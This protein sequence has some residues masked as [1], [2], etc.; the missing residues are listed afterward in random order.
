MT[1]LAAV[2]P[3]CRN[4]LPDA[5]CNIGAPVRCPT[6]DT[7]V[8]VEIFPAFHRS[9]AAGPAA[10][11]ILEE[12]VSSCF[13]HEQKKAVVHCD[14]CGRFLCALCDL[15]FDGQHFCPG[16]LQTGKTTG[17]MP[18]LERRRTLYDSAALTLVFVPVLFLPV[19]IV[20]APVAIYLAVLSWFRP[21]SV[22]Q[23][24]RTRSIVAIVFALAQIAGW[25]SVWYFATRRKI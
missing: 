25:I 20:T 10:E 18:R 23:T 17:T 8:L 21:G 12:G 5:A 14:G 11:T 19:T 13:Y 3:R 7:V 2:C 6:C 24:T 16:C 15:E 4:S 9:P 22:V 1:S